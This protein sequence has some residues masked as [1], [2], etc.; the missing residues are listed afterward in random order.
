MRKTSLLCVLLLLTLGVAWAGDIYIPANTPSVGSRNNWPFNPRFGPEWRYQ[1]VFTAAQL[2]NQPLL[3][4]EIAFAPSGTGTLTAQDF[5]VRMSHTTV[6]A[7]ST[8]ATNLPKPQTVLL[9][10]N[11]VWQTTHQTWSTI[12]LTSAFAY[13]G[14]DSLTIEV[15]YRNG[16]A[17]GFS[18]TCYYD[19]NNHPRIYSR[20]T[21]AYNATTGSMDNHGLK[22]RITFTSAIITLSGTTSPGSTV[23][24]DLDA[25]SDAGKAYQAAS[26][27]G[28]GPIPIGSRVLNLSIDALLDITVNNYLPMIFK[29]YAGNLDAKGKAKAQIMIPNA[30]VL[31]GIRIHSA[32]VTLD[33]SAPFGISL[34]SNTASFTIN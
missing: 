31:K 9:A 26:S 6:P 32:F 27:F 17:A 34:I 29:N 25:P 15:R 24:L 10:K 13:N 11:H 22:I 20:G 7:S 23:D 18:G 30:P 19:S 16:T 8:L 5:E 14:T 28:L 12:G 2:G 3:I 1:M 21:T 33:A 4:N